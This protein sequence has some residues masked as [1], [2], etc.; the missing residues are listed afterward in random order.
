M[1][2]KVFFTWIFDYLEIGFG[3]YWGFRYI[4]VLL[5]GL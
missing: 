1:T 5:P 4:G 3:K 2:L